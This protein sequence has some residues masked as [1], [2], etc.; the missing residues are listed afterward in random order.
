MAGPPDCGLMKFRILDGSATDEEKYWIVSLLE[1][2]KEFVLKLKF[3][4]SKEGKQK[5]SFQSAWFIKYPWLTYSRME[6][7]G[8]CAHCFV[9]AS[10]CSLGV[11]VRSPMVKF[12]KALETL[13]LHDITQYHREA[14]IKAVAFINV[15][16][17]RQ[18]SIANSLNETY[19]ITVQRNRNVLKS[20]M[21]TVEFCGRQGI[22]LR[23][24][25]DDRIYL[26]EQDNNPGNFQALLQFRC[27]A[28]DN[29]LSS[30]FQECSKN[31]TYRSKTT[32]N[33]ILNVFG[34]MIKET[35]IAKVKAGKYYAMI[36]DEVQDA[37]SI[38]QIS[39]VLHYVHKVGCRY[40][41]KESF[42]AFKELHRVMTGAAIA[43]SLLEELKELDLDLDH[44]RG[45]GYDGSG[46]MA[47]SVQGAS[48]IIL[49][50]HP[51]AIFVHCCSHVLNLSI[52]FMF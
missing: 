30:H 52:A 18:A 5:R 4:A 6:N 47:G 25:R 40:T 21:V 19:A 9:F 27:N 35:I 22:A 24:H 33:D 8:Y 42:V 38:E 11:L 51:L 44:L 13:Q 43:E 50:K 46:A 23:G 10:G 45:Q 39:V 1:Q 29:E 7:G 37:P 14:R 41:I 26:D 2:P 17:G 32:Q 34:S 31:S 49:Q 28:G 12:K 3:P 48:S 20:I 16:E 15:M 36:A